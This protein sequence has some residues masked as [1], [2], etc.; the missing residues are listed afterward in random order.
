MI[1]GVRSTLIVCACLLSTT[2]VVHAEAISKWQTP[3]GGLWL[4]N[5]PPAGSVLLETI[6]DTPEPAAKS[7]TAQVSAPQEDELSRAAADGREI[8]RQRAAERT[9]ERA[10]EEALVQNEEPRPEVVVVRTPID[11]FVLG[12]HARRCS[13]S[14]RLSSPSGQMFSPFAPID[15]ARTW[16]AR[17]PKARSISGRLMGRT[18]R[19]K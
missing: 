4:G 8:M 18:T 14:G 3:D 5:R 7:E 12:S 11:V 13:S 16:A 6:E 19:A 9:T 15:P 1:R 2:A 10:Q 17:A